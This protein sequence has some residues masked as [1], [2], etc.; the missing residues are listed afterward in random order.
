MTD[1]REA[2]MGLCAI[3]SG[4]DVALTKLVREEGAREVWDYLCKRAPDGVHARK[5][6]AVDG[7]RLQRLTG[8]C[9]ARFLMPSDAEWPGR[10]NDL[11]WS[12]KVGTFGG[13]PLGLWVLG[14]ADL[15]QLCERS[16]SIVGARAST[17]Y[18]E[19]VSA[20]L[21]FDLAAHRHTVVSGGAYGIDSCAHRG[22]LGGSGKTVAVMAGG[23]A[24]FYPPGNAALIAEVSRSGAVVS[25]LPPDQ[26]PSR[27][28]FLIRNRIIAA[29]S[30]AT[31]IVEG[32]VRSGAQ[33]TVS[34]A[35]SLGRPVLATPGPVTSALSVTPHRLIRDGEAVLV[36]TADEIMDAVRPL[37][38]S[39][40]RRAWDEASTE[41]R[42]TA[43]EQKILDLL[44][45]RRGKCVDDLC[46]LSGE[47]ALEI[48]VVL[49]RLQVAGLAR[50]VRSGVWRAVTR[51]PVG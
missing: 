29:L 21:A 17:S 33:N 46:D 3:R 15:G 18:G 36:S 49:S 25:E 34:W 43:H 4:G 50:E 13:E 35:L 10:L 9:G 41:D 32:A 8:A 1:E 12:G 26:A 30:L 23:L 28:G 31:V 24:E 19:H 27:A 40:E 22:A 47:P 39:T 5:A 2:R 38:D 20:E 14:E 6:R 11:S 44:P 37:E 16:V 42:L 7:A 51:T 48:L 45:L